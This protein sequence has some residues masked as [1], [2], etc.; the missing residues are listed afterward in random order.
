M[1][2]TR[3]NDHLA[4]VYTGRCLAVWNPQETI[5]WLKSL[6]RGCCQWS[7]TGDSLLFGDDS[8]SLQRLFIIPTVRQLGFF[9]SSPLT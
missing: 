7:A 5:I 9:S 6:P 4:V 3:E 2:W 1:E 8:L